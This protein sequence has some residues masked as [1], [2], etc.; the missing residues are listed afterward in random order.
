M[1]C[2]YVEYKWQTPETCAHD[3]IV[4]V[5]IKIIRKLGLPFDSKILDAGY[6]GGGGGGGLAYTLYN[7]FGFKNVYG[8]DA[9]KSG[10]DVAKNSFPEIA[11][12]FF[13]HNTYEF[14]LPDYIPQRFDLI[15]SMEVIEHLYN[16]KA[17]LA[18]INQWLKND[19]YLILTTPYHG[20]L[21]NLLIA[22]TGKFDRHVDSLCDVG[23]IKFFSRETLYRLLK[24]AGIKLLKYYGLGRLPFLW[25][26]M[27]VAAKK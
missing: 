5:I 22:L 17:Y 25:K 21:K 8:F 4:P 1:Q 12:K 27:V 18:N 15:I 9:S 26:S 19:V 20:Y 13:I 11:E 7:H 10:I 24:E 6:G 16:P 14:K 23:H 2:K 3:Y